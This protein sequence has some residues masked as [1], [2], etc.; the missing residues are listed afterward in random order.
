MG[1][2]LSQ[3]STG[4]AIAVC[5]QLQR[6]ML[7][8]CGQELLHI[9]EPM[10]QKV[11]DDVVA[12]DVACERDGLKKQIVNERSHLLLGAA[13]DQPLQHATAIAM[14]CYLSSCSFAL[15]HDFL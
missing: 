6:V 4:I 15:G 2:S 14:P 10:L 8:L 5:Y 1:K 7:K 13:L 12:V 9:R 3:D 11:L